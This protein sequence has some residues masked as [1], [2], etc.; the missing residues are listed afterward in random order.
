MPDLNWPAIDGAPDKNNCGK[1]DSIAKE[2]IQEMLQ[3]ENLRQTV[4]QQCRLSARIPQ[5]LLSLQ[6]SEFFPVLTD[7]HPIKLTP[8][9]SNLHVE[10][11]ERSFT[12]CSKVMSGLSLVPLPWYAL[13]TATLF[14]SYESE[15]SV[16]STHPMGI[17][18]YKQEKQVQLDVVLTHLICTRVASQVQV[19]PLLTRCRFTVPSNHKSQGSRGVTTVCLVY[20]YIFFC[21]QHLKSRIWYEMHKKGEKIVKRSCLRLC[22]LPRNHVS[23]M[24]D[25]QR[26]GDRKSPL[27]I[28]GTF[29]AP[30]AD[31]IETEEGAAFCEQSQNKL[32]EA[33]QYL[34][35][36]N[37]P[38]DSTLVARMLVILTDLRSVQSLCHQ[39]REELTK[40][41]ANEIAEHF[42]PAFL[43][44]VDFLP[45]E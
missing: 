42:P 20:I 35:T 29:H 15:Y 7:I 9:D 23:N 32:I 27:D 25:P 21:V 2:P 37:H 6:S 14:A 40:L 3:T 12:V 26:D 13:L 31:R 10:K 34:I 11:P 38:N 1:A 39:K 24:G 17:T 22:E 18:R 8:Y 16:L 33:L 28:K 36:E 43:Q 30:F 44:F 45:I 5:G 4:L 19:A 41:C